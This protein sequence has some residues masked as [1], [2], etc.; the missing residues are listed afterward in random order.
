MKT[1]SNLCALA[2]LAVCLA[3]VASPASGQVLFRPDK[4]QVTT[5]PQTTDKVG[6]TQ[7]T[8]QRGLT[9]EN[10]FAVINSITAKATPIAAD[11][12]VIYDSVAAAPKSCTL[13]QMFA[14]G[15][16]LADMSGTNLDAGASGTAGTVDVF[17]ATAASGKLAITAADSAGDFT[18]TIV[19]ASQAAA[20][21]YTV[22][23]AGGA[24]DFV[25]TAGAQTIAGVKTFSSA[26]RSTANAGAIVANKAT[27]V[28]IGDGT[29]HQTVLTL[30]LTGAHD[31]DLADGGHGAGI[32][33][34]DLPEGR[35]LVLG[36][37]CDVSVA[38][39]GEFNATAAD[40]FSLAVGTAVAADDDALTSTEADLIPVQTLDTESGATTPLAAKAALAAS[41]QF[42]GTTTPIDVCVN[43]ACA[44]ANNSDATTY[45][46]TGT[47]TL[48]WINLGD[49]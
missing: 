45:A 23:D 5:S 30:T 13:A 42:D 24:A 8:S 7:G 6:I 25:M 27:A 43:V 20:R 2:I 19:N 16:T 22:P 33:V 39:N 37:T 26:T 48:T 44:D 12:V 29:I 32:K 10:V 40:T 1:K 21:T 49:Y 41:A 4:L 38:H 15:I 46:V 17:P 35:I 28:E 11:K 3:A 18:T 47:L 34:Y 14:A 31:L 9:L 36:A